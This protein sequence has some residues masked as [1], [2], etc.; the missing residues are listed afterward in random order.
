MN[1]K[2]LRKQILSNPK[3][4]EERNKYKLSFE[5]AEMVMDARVKKHMSQ[6]EL[7]KRVGTKQPGIARLESGDV[8]PSLTLLKKVAK[9]LEVELK[10]QFEE[11]ISARQG[12]PFIIISTSTGDEREVVSNEELYNYANI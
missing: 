12:I 4:Q 11:N 2:N 10:L 5:I 8:L 9:A 3:V 1:Y 6:K 7:A